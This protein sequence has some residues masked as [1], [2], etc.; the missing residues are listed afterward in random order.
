MKLVIPFTVLSLV[1]LANSFTQHVWGALIFLLGYSEV[2]YPT[3]TT[4]MQHGHNN[5]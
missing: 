3:H 2:R 1:C 4:I 5:A